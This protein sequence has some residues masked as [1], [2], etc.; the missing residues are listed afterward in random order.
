MLEDSHLPSQFKYHSAMLSFFFLELLRVISLDS[1]KPIHEGK[2]R[3]RLDEFPE[4]MLVNICCV[5]P[6]SLLGETTTIHSLPQPQCYRG[7]NQKNNNKK[8][9]N[10]RVEIKTANRKER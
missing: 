3:G 4:K 2:V 6:S 8:K 9:N 7:E 5:V 1:F 10:S